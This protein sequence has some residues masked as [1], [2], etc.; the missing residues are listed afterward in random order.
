[1]AAE[2]PPF[3]LQNASH[4]A[5]LVRQAVASLKGARLPG[6]YTN[7][8]WPAGVVGAG[9]LAVSANSTPNMSVNVA[10]GQAW[11][12]GSEAANQ[13]LYY[14]FNDAP[15]NL[16]VAASDPTNP[17]YD[18]VA[19]TVLD[20]AYA[21]AS[22]EWLLQVITG[23]AA[24]SPVAPSLPANSLALALV[25]V[26]AAA[27]SITSADI[28]FPISQTAFAPPVYDAPLQG[29][30]TVPA[31]G[32]GAIYPGTPNV[33][34]VGGND[35]TD[36][37]F[38]VPPGCDGYYVVNAQMTG[39]LPS[40]GEFQVAIEVNGTVVRRG[41]AY[42]SNNIITKASTMWRGHLNVGDVVTVA[43]ANDSGSTLTVISDNTTH[44]LSL[45]RI[46]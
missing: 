39:S 20:A 9:D 27:S 44:A 23:T 7:N 21:G 36:H 33:D 1:M 40:A 31:N 32:T 46:G 38:K 8:A 22:N 17:R 5:A 41:H 29:N 12:A 13:G 28:V 26:P 25:S 3:V 2:N 45:E 34:T 19:A 6:T 35:T 16:V 24:A 42:S 37:G 43:Y 10:A 15:V 11:I 4:S 30:F 18:L 14:C